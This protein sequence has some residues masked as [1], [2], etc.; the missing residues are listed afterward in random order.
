MSRYY[1]C[2][3]A[4]NGS[5]HGR[6]WRPGAASESVDSER[7]CQGHEH[8]CQIRPSWRLLPLFYLSR[9]DARRRVSLGL[10]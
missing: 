6:Y 2:P 5:S 4:W 9:T 8:A 3:E 10:L 7:S 1:Q